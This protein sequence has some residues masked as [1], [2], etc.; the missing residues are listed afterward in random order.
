MNR[1]IARTLIAAS[2]T[3]LLTLGACSSTQECCSSEGKTTITQAEK[4]YGEPSKVRYGADGSE[5]WTWEDKG[6]SI[7]FKDGV[8]LGTHQH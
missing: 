8:A 5:T 1:I 3:A 4:M 6:M 2:S 7:T